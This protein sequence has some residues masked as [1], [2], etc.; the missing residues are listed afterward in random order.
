MTDML[1]LY[2]HLR[3]LWP[4]ELIG[5]LDGT[6]HRYNWATASHSEHDEI[7]QQLEDALDWASSNNLLSPDLRGRLSGKDRK[8]FHSAKDELLVGKFLTRCGQVKPATALP[9]GRV[10]DWLI[11]GGPPIYVE[12]KSIYDVDDEAN[13][14]QAQLLQTASSIESGRTLEVSVITPGTLSSKG[15]RAYLEKSLA[16]LGTKICDEVS[17]PDYVDPSG[18]TVRVT[19]LPFPSDGPTRLVI[20]SVGSGPITSHL[21]V[22]RRARQGARQLPDPDEAIPA[23]VVICRHSDLPDTGFESLGA[24]FSLPAI[25]LQTGEWTV[26]PEGMSRPDRHTRVSAIAQYF[27]RPEKLEVVHNP[28]AKNPIER[29]RLSVPGIRQLVPEEPGRM[30]WIGG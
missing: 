27:W 2:P 15:F 19:C 18:L 11:Y 26:Q 7:R 28:F 9:S 25:N 13:R 21:Q 16:G 6:D 22:Q 1:D 10:G 23:M 24:M 14:T 5:S 3:S 4:R 30:R 20:V 8:Q 12:V 17:L 29:A